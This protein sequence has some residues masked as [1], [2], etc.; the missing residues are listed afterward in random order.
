MAFSITDLI[1]RRITVKI[2]SAAAR[3]KAL[4]WIVIAFLL[5]APSYQSLKAD[6]PQGGG[7]VKLI[8]DY[9]QREA[10]LKKAVAWQEQMTVLDVLSESATVTKEKIEGYTLVTAINGVHTKPGEMAWYYSLNGKAGEVMSDR[11]KVEKDDIIRWT[12]L[13]DSCTPKPSE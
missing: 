11:Q 13:E 5:A 4:L 1:K 9:G 8:I 6:T 3:R 7:E 10:L 2:S 12:F